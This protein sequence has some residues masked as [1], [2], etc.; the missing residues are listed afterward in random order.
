MW[1][2]LVQHKDGYEWHAF[3]DKLPTPKPTP[4]V[5]KYPD[6]HCEY[7]MTGSPPQGTADDINSAKDQAEA[8]IRS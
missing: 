3:E 1:K 5:H 2:R 8:L 7:G 6:G 4:I